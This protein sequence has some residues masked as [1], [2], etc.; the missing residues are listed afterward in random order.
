M[1]IIEGEQN[2]INYL[3]L[4][5]KSC[6]KGAKN[7]ESLL[8]PIFPCHYIWGPLWQDSCMNSDKRGWQVEKVIGFWVGVQ[9]LNFGD[10]RSIFI[11]HEDL[12][13]FLFWE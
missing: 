5:F 3:K 11:K 10:S 2:K 12:R 8:L 4:Y 13:H 9:S 7:K 6:K 1:L